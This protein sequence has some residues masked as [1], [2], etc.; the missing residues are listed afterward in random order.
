MKNIPRPV[1]NTS[2]SKCRSLRM[3]RPAIE[4]FVR[5]MYAMTYERKQSGISRR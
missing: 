5:S 3:F 4:T 1:P 2:S